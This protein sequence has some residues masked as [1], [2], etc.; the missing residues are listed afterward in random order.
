MNQLP[1]VPV[2]YPPNSLLHC[3]ALVIACVNGFVRTSVA[4]NGG[5]MATTM[6]MHALHIGTV[7][8]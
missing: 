8:N 4:C 7:I 6:E 1:H 3:P 5:I 2:V